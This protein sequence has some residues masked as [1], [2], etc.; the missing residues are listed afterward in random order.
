MLHRDMHVP[1]QLLQGH[2]LILQHQMP[3]ISAYYGILSIGG[4]ANGHRCDYI[5]VTMHK[6]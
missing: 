4:R 1:C 5:L 6:K 3:C 2:A